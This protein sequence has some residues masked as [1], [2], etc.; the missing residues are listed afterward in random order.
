M[1]QEVLRILRNTHPNS[2]EFW[3]EDITNFCQRMKNSGWEE[4]IRLRAIKSGITGWVRIINNEIN[5]NI[6]RY[7]PSS[8]KKI[9]RAKE[10]LAKGDNW[11]KHKNKPESEQPIAALLLDATPNSQIKQ[12]FETRN[13]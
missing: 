10:K 7:R 6:P 8:F 9:E 2:G 12:I 13:S 3:K 11:Y 1:G 5:M 4:S